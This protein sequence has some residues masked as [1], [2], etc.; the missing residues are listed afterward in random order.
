VGKEK[1]PKLIETLGLCYLGMVLLRLPV[2]LGEIYKWAAEEEV[3]YTRAV[4]THVLFILRH[5]LTSVQIKEIPKEMRTRLPPY[6]YAALEIRAQLRG[7]SL[8]RTVLQLVEF[9]NVQFE[10]VFPP[11][12]A[13]LLI[14]KHIRDLGLPRKPSI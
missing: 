13:P 8:Y 7:S 4:S 3:I 5:L 6:Y 12:N 10:M 11:L 9:F 2:S 14:F 1:L